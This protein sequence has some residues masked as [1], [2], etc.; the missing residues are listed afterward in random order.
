M[1]FENRID[2][3]IQLCVDRVLNSLGLKGKQTLLKY[4]EKDIGLREDEIPENPALFSKGLRLL[5]GEKGADLI[6]AS[7]MEGLVSNF[8][9]NQT[10][11]LTFAKAI[12]MIKT[13]ELEP[14]R[15][16]KETGCLNRCS[17][18]LKT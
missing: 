13:A 10:S 15:N 16:S 9:L 14:C 4:L 12:G 8:E 1:P 17:K 2:Q 5:L 3:K 6:E 18:R 11:D 7:I